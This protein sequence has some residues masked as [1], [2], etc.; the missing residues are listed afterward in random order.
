MFVHVR[1]ILEE[2]QRRERILQMISRRQDQLQ[3]PAGLEAVCHFFPLQQVSDELPLICRRPFASAKW[4][5]EHE[6]M[7]DEHGAE[8]LR[9]VLECEPN[10][11]TVLPRSVAS[12][13]IEYDGGKR[14][15]TCRPPQEAFQSKTATRNLDSLRARRFR[16]MR[17]SVAAKR[18]R[19]CEHEEWSQRASYGAS[20]QA[21]VDVGG[22]AVY[23]N[24]RRIR[25]ARGNDSCGS[26]A[27]GSDGRVPTTRFWP[28]PALTDLNQR[29]DPRDVTFTVS[30]PFATAC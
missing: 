5:Q 21:D 28:P 14:T 25:G 13:V 20:A 2:R 15:A 19:D 10:L 23:R 30:T 27:S 16:A 29:R 1:K 9:E 3:L 26:G 7:P 22:E 18:Q 24:R 4:I 8:N 11:E 6:T 12:A 17:D